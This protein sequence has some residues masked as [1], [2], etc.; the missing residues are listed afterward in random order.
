MFHFNL[1]F[2]LSCSSAPSLLSAETPLLVKEIHE[3]RPCKLDSTLDFRL[4]H[5]PL[6]SRNSA[7]YNSILLLTLRTLEF[8]AHAAY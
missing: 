8:I 7:Y 6:I 3:H 2:S 5:G 1:S 4:L